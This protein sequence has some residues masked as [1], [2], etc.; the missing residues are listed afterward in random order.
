MA[1]LPAEIVALMGKM[2]LDTNVATAGEGKLPYELMDLVRE[3]L[4]PDGTP[5][6]MSIEEAR[7][8]RLELMKERH[9]FEKT[10]E[11]SWQEHSYQWG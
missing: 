7:Q 3:Y 9:E 2:S 11:A 6:L 5:M 4:D 1:K 10:C 8:H